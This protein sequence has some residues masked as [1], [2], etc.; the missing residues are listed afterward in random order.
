MQRVE[1]EEQYEEVMD[2][3][4]ELLFRINCFEMVIED[5]ESDPA[6][7]DGAQDILVTLL[8][9]RRDA[10]YARLLI[11]IDPKIV[12]YRSMLRHP[13]FQEVE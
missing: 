2:E 12:R 13:A 11:E 8:K 1:V 10:H 4:H 6:V 9:L 7:G 3:M 5:Y